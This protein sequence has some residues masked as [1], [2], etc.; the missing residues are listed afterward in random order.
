M[1]HFLIKKDQ[2]KQGTMG[3]LRVNIISARNLPNADLYKSDPYAILSCAGE[4]HRTKTINNTL[5]PTY[6][7]MF[8]FNNASPFTDLRVMFYDKDFLKDDMLCSCIISLAQVPQGKPCNMYI[9]LRPKGE[10]NVELLAEDFG[11]VSASAAPMYVGQ[12]NMYASATMVPQAPPANMY[13]NPYATTAP[14]SGYYYQQPYTG[15]SQP[16]PPMPNYYPPSAPPMQGQPPPP[17]VPNPN[18]YPNYPPNNPYYYP[19]Q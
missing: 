8:Y 12:P 16:A 19:R 15:M 6:N 11:Q 10:L 2:N 7:E 18:A 13:P 17:L 5:N 4:Q 14:P 1:D 3:R 9:P